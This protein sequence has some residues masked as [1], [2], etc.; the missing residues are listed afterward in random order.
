MAPKYEI[1]SCIKA[2]VIELYRDLSKDTQNFIETT[3]PLPLG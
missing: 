1:A 2:K 3:L